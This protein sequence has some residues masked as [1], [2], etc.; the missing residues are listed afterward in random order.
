MDVAILNRTKN[1]IQLDYQE[2]SAKTVGGK[3]LPLFLQTASQSHETPGYV[4][5]QG[6]D[7]RIA[8]DSQ[9]SLQHR[10]TAIVH[11]EE[12]QV[13]LTYRD[14]STTLT[15]NTHPEAT[16]PG[17][18]LR[19]QPT[20]M[21]TPSLAEAEQ[22]N[23]TVIDLERTRQYEKA[24]PLAKRALALREEALGPLHPD[25]AQSL[26][27]LA[28]LY[29][30]QRA[31]D[32]AQPLFQRA[33]AILE[34]ALGPTHLHVAIALI[35][36]ADLY[37]AQGA[38]AQAEPLYQR[39]LAIR[40]QALG[41]THPAVAVSLNN[42]AVLYKA[43]GAYD[44]AGPLFQRALALAEQAR[45]P[46]HPD[47]ATA[48]SNLATLFHT[49]GAYPQAE[50]LYQRALAI[51]EQA[52][53]PTH[54]DV[55]S[56]L[57]NLAL[58]YHE[59][60]AYPQ[61]EPL[62]QRALAIREQALG[63]THPDVASVLNNLGGLY[64]QKRAYAQAEPLYQRALAIR[65][66]VLGSAH[67]EIAT[68][69]HNLAGL[70][71]DQEAYAQAEPLYQRAL[72]IQEQ[73]LG[74]THPEV[75]SVLNNLADLYYEHG[76][77]AQAEPLYQ[78]AL[79]IREQA[80][81]PTH[82]AVAHSLNHLAWLS[83]AQHD[84]SHAIMY[85]TRA[86]EISERNIRLN[87]TTGSEL[88][89]LR[90]LA[91]MSR[92]THRIIALHVEVAPDDLAA[93]QL[94]LT[95]ILRRKGRA[96]DATVDTLATL[97]RR[98]DAQAQALLDQWSTTR[99][100]LAALALG[101]PRTLVPGQYLATVRR[102]A[103]QA[104]ALEADLSR[105]SAAFRVESQPVTIEAVQAAIPPEAALVEFVQFTPYDFQ[106]STWLAPRYAAY[107]LPPE[108]EPR[109]VSLEDAATIEAA[110][111]AFR[112]A[113]RDPTRSE[114]KHLA[115][116]LDAK[117]MQPVRTLLG[118][119]QM[120]FLSPDGPLHLV[121]FAALVD[122]QERYLVEHYQFIYLTT[123]R[124][125]LP[126]QV[127]PPSTQVPLVIADPDFD[128][129]QGNTD[130]QGNA[131]APSIP[132]P[133]PT[134]RVA[135]NLG[136]LSFAPLPETAAEGQA[137]QGLLPSA[138]VLTRAK[139]TKQALKDHPTPHIL[140]IA[141]HGFF[142]D[143][144]VHRPPSLAGRALLLSDESADTPGGPEVRLLHPLLRSG[145]ALA[146][147][148]KLRSGEGEGILT[149]LE[150]A[151]LPLWGTQLV[152]LSACDTGVGMVMNGEGVHGLRR[153]LV[154]AG[155]A[156]QMMSL[157][158]V[159]DEGTRDLM[160]A[161]YTALQAGQGRGEALQQVQRQL[162]T[163]PDRQHPFYWASFIQSGEWTSV[164]GQR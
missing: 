147:A 2:F 45:G 38:Y 81:G 97:R 67:P 73:A 101:T 99:T 68:S 33:L 16:P 13:V 115:R 105:Q 108:G 5:L 100:R 112:A 94:A 80:L 124:D 138:T 117:L 131:P 151:A 110:I 69:L 111:H 134:A 102:L 109:W 82:P 158:P 140:H 21:A 148:N 1:P 75:A 133:P 90:Y 72:A 37:K 46:T 132:P 11:D 26:N 136:Q 137:L 17:T 125:L 79:A 161:Y 152:V 88:Q 162:L 130:A 50:P 65:E 63:P 121:P 4:R 103:A 98:S 41:P 160:I 156:T 51:R 77:Y 53:G 40:E 34:Q 139:A 113:L 154:L 56:V 141:T 107:V 122:E 64:K 143:E 58:L 39:A 7:K 129:G 60:G 163:R 18:A 114:V 12:K 66:Q 49:Q 23:K 106:R 95:T 54:P 61:A 35:N 36:L 32:Q 84:L 22:L 3:T 52:L 20:V 14:W 91:T 93:R 43:Q 9:G 96:L 44:Q 153:A 126:R 142:F 76:A 29:E 24:L 42:L 10:F 155:A 164:P 30:A 123:G 71:H 62:Y 57:N 87:L 83:A 116:A 25:V 104:D 89:K 145:L 120:V 146:G 47:V 119:T 135:V 74:P 118:A 6:I 31:Y 15:V 28:T 128:T 144:V 149:A 92:E 59:R 86:A 159:S 157:W 19:A 85:Q 127:P 55:A 48:L 70:Y 8:L 78:R 150:A 27:N